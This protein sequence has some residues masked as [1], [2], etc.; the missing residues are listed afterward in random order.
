MKLRFKKPWISKYIRYR[1]RR[2]KYGKQDYFI[3]RNLVITTKRIEETIDTYGNEV[4]NFCEK[5]RNVKLKRLWIYA[6]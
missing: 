6:Q 4:V 3:S 1:R 5:K 2:T